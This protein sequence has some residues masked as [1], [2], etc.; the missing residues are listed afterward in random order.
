MNYKLDCLAYIE[1]ETKMPKICLG[2]WLTARNLCPCMQKVVEFVSEESEYE[3]RSV[4][5]FIE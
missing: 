3:S 5:S 1:K 2:E 4:Q